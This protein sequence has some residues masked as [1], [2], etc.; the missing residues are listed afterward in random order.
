MIGVLGYG[1]I[2]IFFHLLAVLNPAYSSPF[3]FLIHYGRYITLTL[4]GGVWLWRARKEPTGSGVLTVLVAFFA[5][6]HAFSI[7]YLMWPIAFAVLKGDQRT[8]QWLLRY[9]LGA[10]AYMLLTYSILILTPA[11]TIW[12][13][14]KQADTFFIRPLTLPAWLVA[15]VWLIDRLRTSTLYTSDDKSPI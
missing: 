13:P 11:I 3:A 8:E 7:Q 9:T 6:T 10:F 5:T 2:L 1:D 4:L 12:V 15:V 14:W